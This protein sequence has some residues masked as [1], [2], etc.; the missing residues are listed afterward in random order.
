MYKIGANSE[1]LYEISVLWDQVDTPGF[2]NDPL[3]N[4]DYIIYWNCIGISWAKKNYS[5]IEVSP[6]KFE[7]N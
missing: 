4:G 1:T 2:V 5:Q 7:Q 3:K 6:K